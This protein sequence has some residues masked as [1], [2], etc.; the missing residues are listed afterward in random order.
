MNEPSWLRLGRYALLIA[1]SPLIP[2]P[3]VDSHV[4]TVLRRRLVRRMAEEQG[5]TIESPEI[6]VLADM[7]GSGCLGL[8][9]SVLLWPI[10]KILRVVFFFLSAKAM[11]DTFSEVVHR[12]L[13]LSEAL[14]AG[15]L[16]GKEAEVRA[17]MDG[18]LERVD[19]RVLEVSLTTAFRESR[20]ALGGVADAVRGF[21]GSRPE[22]ETALE[23]AVEGGAVVELDD[24]ATSLASVVQDRGPWTE[25]RHDFR[26]GLGLNEETPASE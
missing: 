2:I 22:R 8:L 4:E 16:P 5:V 10:K 20:S 23:E 12:G 6:R 7:P 26:E 24:M 19:T 9:F 17:A 13:M 21:V 11:A 18:A 15:L 1:L 14:D 25:I 3:F